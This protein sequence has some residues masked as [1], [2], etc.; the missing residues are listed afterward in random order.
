MP[1]RYPYIV[2]GARPSERA[3]K[4]AYLLSNAASGQFLL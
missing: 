2:L 4:F 1:G 3:L